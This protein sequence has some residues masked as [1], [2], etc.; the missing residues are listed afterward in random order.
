MTQIRAIAFTG[1]DGRRHLAAVDA[2]GH[3]SD[4]GPGELGEWIAR[5]R[6]AG[7]WPVEL[8]E[9]ARAAL[10]AGPALT[11]DERR[12]RVVGVDETGA[13]A[14]LALPVAAPEV[15][16]AGVTYRRSREA[17]EAETAA[18]TKDIYSRVYEATRPELF[19]KDSGGR[20][21]VPSGGSIHVRTDSHWSVPEPELALVL[22]AGG[23]IVGYTAA[24]DVSA[25]DIEGENPLYLPQAKVYRG[26]CALGPAVLL[27]D[28]PTAGSFPIELRIFDGN[29]VP[30]FLGTTNTSAM[31]RSFDDLV[32]AL[33]CD[34]V[35]DDGTVLSTGTG[36][37]PPD[38]F[39]LA[40][41]QRV[42]IEIGGVGLLWNT[43]DGG[44]TV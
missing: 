11:L 43:V 24:N 40:P 37:V 1:G 22:D 10:V 41:G 21:T 32:G 25:R 36:V 34:N 19:L 5:A 7:M 29:G 14:S 3:V 31:A 9:R 27:V 23:R 44:R 33:F 17:R 35:I 18:S 30:V 39:T 4:L 26:S 15:W 6:V 2:L 12:A 42:E 13:G 20:R 16:A 38:G 8:I 28:G